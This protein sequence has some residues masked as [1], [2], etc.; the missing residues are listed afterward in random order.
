MLK[1][2]LY[3]RNR[4]RT[5]HL[6]TG[7]C[8]CVLVTPAFSAI[9]DQLSGVKSEISRQEQQLIDKNRKLNTLQNSLKKQEEA[10]SELAN[11]IR[12]IRSNLSILADEISTL[13]K[14]SKRLKKTKKT[15]HTLLEQLLNS[16]YRQG[17]HAPLS[18]IL[19]S[20][21]NSNYDRMTVY[22]ARLSRQRF[23]MIQA[24]TQTNLELDKKRNA[25][26]QQTQ[27]Q[28]T[29][30]ADLRA[31]KKSFENQKKERQKTA[32]A[33][34]RQI[35]NDESYLA[36]LKD[37]KKRLLAELDK[38]KELARLAAEENSIQMDG[39]RKDRGTLQWPV[40]GDVLHKYG[41]PQ[42]GK[43]HWTGIVISAR[44][45]SEVKATDDGTVVLSN[46]LRG[47]GLMVVIDHGKGDMS[48]YGYNQALLKNVGDRVKAGEP[49]A[50]V[51]SSGG[52]TS[53]GLYF[54]I[55]SKGNTVN[56][57]PWLSR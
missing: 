31:N 27:R 29:L 12:N 11:K 3:G 16:Q 52:Q 9:D 24:L 34:R 39:L 47:Y 18:A 5:K 15:Q 8:L 22:V 38:A 55:R 33:I 40:K 35:E 53:S 45:G 2:F 4:L 30:L 48:F 1:N 13:N 42:T 20:D 28:N 14:E 19:G 43:I 7:V 37:N 51:G 54:E 41:S 6:I 23:E 44:E 57:E 49:V 21:D 25:L 17:K 56:P 32:R 46:W 50:L 10:I 26:R 36:E